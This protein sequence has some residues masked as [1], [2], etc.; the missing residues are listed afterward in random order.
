MR[1]QKAEFV[2]IIKDHEAII[3]KIVRVYAM[4]IEN[5]K[6]L[7]QEIVFQL[8][9]SFDSFKG[10][11]KISTWIYRIALNTSI[12]HLNREKKIRNHSTIDFNLLQLADTQDNLKEERIKVLYAHIQQ[13]T[14]I[15]RGL[16]LLFLEGK[17]YEEMAAITGFTVTNVGT[18][19]G[20][21]KQKLKAQIKKVD[22]WN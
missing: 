21:I 4:D 5:Q 15:E 8:W 22:L 16:I 2:Q 9:K 20:R 14:L 17:S 6:D 11:S 19:L 13:L 18:R 1:Q 3:Y 7:Y 10:A 12:T